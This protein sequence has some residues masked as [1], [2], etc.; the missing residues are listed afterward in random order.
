M[1][2][3]IV[4]VIFGLQTAYENTYWRKDETLFGHSVAQDPRH[5]EGL[6]QLSR[7]ALE[8]G[9]YPEAA[10]L[11]AD[12]LEQLKDPSYVAYGVPYYAH[13]RLGTAFLHL[14]QPALALAQFQEAQ[15]FFPDSPGGYA[16]LAMAEVSLGNL[17]AARQ[18]SARAVEL[19]PYDDE[20][21]HNLVLTLLQ[22]NEFE[23]ALENLKLLV[24]SQPGNAGHHARLAYCQW[25]LGN[26]EEAKDNLDQAHRLD[27]RDPDVLRV[28]K[29]IGPGL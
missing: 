22:L 20:L 1:L 21:R 28:D 9:D 29:M 4:A 3:T 15:R 10:R 27:S 19:D 18:Y 8:S 12:A 16:S 7:L 14:Q 25:K 6:I 24:E 23:E 11:A 13:S 17:P 26:R 2:M 5:I